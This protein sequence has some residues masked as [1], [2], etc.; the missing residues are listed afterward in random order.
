MKRRIWALLLAALVALPLAGCRR[1]FEGHISE[2]CY[3]HGHYWFGYH[4]YTITTV[5][6]QIYAKMAFET[7]DGMADP[8]LEGWE[9][10]VALTEAESG[11]FD[12]LCLKTLRLPE[13]KESYVDDSVTDMDSW[14]L[15]YTWSGEEYETGGYA[16]YPEG[17]SAIRAFFEDLDWPEG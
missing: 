16:V 7:T 11:A 14:G 4:V 13:W 5:D 9:V 17:L 1:S 8:E 15:A 6:D 3:T 10:Q 2:F 12:E